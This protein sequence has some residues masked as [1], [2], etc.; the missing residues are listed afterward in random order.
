MSLLEDGREERVLGAETEQGRAEG[1]NGERDQARQLGPAAAR[2]FD[3]SRVAERL[4]A[5]FLAAL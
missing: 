2:R 5:A 1:A 4:E 3:S